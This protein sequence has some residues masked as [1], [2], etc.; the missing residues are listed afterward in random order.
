MLCLCA[1]WRLPTPERSTPGRLPPG[2]THPAES[3]GCRRFWNLNCAYPTPGLS[4]PATWRHAYGASAYP[5][6]MHSARWNSGMGRAGSDE[7]G[8][9]PPELRVSWDERNAK[10]GDE[11]YVAQ[12]RYYPMGLCLEHTLWG[13]TLVASSIFVSAFG[14]HVLYVTND[15]LG[16]RHSARNGPVIVPGH[17]SRTVL[18]WKHEKC[19]RSDEFY[20]AQR[21]YHL[22][23]LCL[24]YTLWD[25][26]LVDSSIFVSAH[27][28]HI[29]Y[30]TD[31]TLE[32]WHSAR[33]GHVGALGHCSRTVLIW[34]HYR[35]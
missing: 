5:C 2:R 35:A 30:V 19:K 12:R 18:V 1:E 27:G 7:R 3:A 8:S 4:G 11:V 24:E 31:N 20:V 15:A 9:H 28:R 21:I 22:M 34:E 17:C 14:H 33:N 23:G 10:R 13:T 16:Q 6:R 26:T 25:T 32:Q 29:L